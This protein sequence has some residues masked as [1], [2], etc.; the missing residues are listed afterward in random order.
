MKIGA[1]ILALSVTACSGYE[2]Q[3]PTLHSSSEKYQSDNNDDAKGQSGDGTATGTGTGTATNP[4]LPDGTAT[5]PVVNPPATTPVP[6]PVKPGK[7][8]ESLKLLVFSK[9][10][11][12]RHGDSIEVGIKAMK[13]LGVKYGFTVDATEDSAQFTKENLA[14]YTVVFFLNTTGEI[15]DESQRA[16]FEGYI[17]A[18]GG[19]VGAHAAADTLYTWPFY[20]KLVG[21]WFGG[22][23]A[24]Q[25]AK[26]K[27]ED[28][29]H[30][31]TS[32][33]AAVVEREDEWYNYKTNPRPD[34]T[35]L[36]SLDESSYE[37]GSMKGDHPITWCHE[38][39]GGRAWYTGFGHTKETFT[40]ADTIKLFMGGLLWA[41]NIT[42]V[43][44]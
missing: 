12:Y 32:F 40:N 37:G 27:V 30:I 25:K 33:F 2:S 10:G 14:K 19:Y 7:G 44:L 39:E 41:A 38:F 18:G 1:I 6:D 24:I 36:M 20:G 26:V 35:V 4:T 17:K 15:L 3:R 43:K 5:N 29:K 21:A 22:H 16:A 42:T 8:I 23:P 31:S 28:N 34:V 11:G 13:D 9:T